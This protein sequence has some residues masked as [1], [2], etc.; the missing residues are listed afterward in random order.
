[1]AA[2]KQVLVLIAHNADQIKDK[3]FIAKGDPY[4]KKQIV[5]DL[6]SRLRLL[7]SQGYTPAIWSMVTYKKMHRWGQGTNMGRG[8]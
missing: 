6:P 3:N 1:M 8:G 2:D 4:G 5:F 7:C